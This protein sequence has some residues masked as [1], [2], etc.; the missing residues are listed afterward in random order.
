[1]ALEVGIGVDRGAREANFVVEVRRG[2]SA[3]FA[4]PG[5]DF[6]A[7]DA[8]ARDHI[9]AREVTV[10]GLHSVAVVDDYE[11]AIASVGI[12]ELDLATGCG[13]DR[14]ASGNGNVDAGVEGAVTAKGVEA[15]AIK[16]GEA[17]L[18]RPEA[19]LVFKEI[20]GTN[21]TRCVE[22]I[23]EGGGE[24]SV[25]QEVVVFNR[26]LKGGGKLGFEAERFLGFEL[27]LDAVGD[28]DFAC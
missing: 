18:D 21:G 25:A 6:T 10:V 2:G 27:A 26:V 16:T 28:G 15:L 17:A 5:D 14:S 22:G 24:G 1:M 23:A 4:R 8:L 3:C 20:A 9:E 13:N 7:G 19:G 12:A 11:T